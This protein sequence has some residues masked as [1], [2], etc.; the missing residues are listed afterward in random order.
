MYVDIA[1]VVDNAVD[2]LLQ[3]CLKLTLCVLANKYRP[4]EDSIA[5]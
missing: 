2:V 5:D 4:S 3:L 1:L